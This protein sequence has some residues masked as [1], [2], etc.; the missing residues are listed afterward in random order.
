[1]TDLL[2]ILY[3]W[4]KAFHII[5]VIAWMAGIFYLPRL[6]VHHVEQANNAEMRETFRMMEEK[7][8]TVIMRPAMVATWVFGLCL[9]LTPG[10]VDWGL[11][12]PWSKAGGVLLMTAFHGWL[13][14]C[15]RGFASG[16]NEVT[17]RQYRIMNEAPTLLM[18]VI[19]ISVVVKF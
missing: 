10:I 12:W 9:A 18:V 17:G 1:M 15:Y 2:S 3:P 5:A 14:R 11:I 4:T 16:E 6:F 7:L 8:L 13:S 19:V